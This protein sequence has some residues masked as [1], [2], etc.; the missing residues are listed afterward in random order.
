V[1]ERYLKYRDEG[2][3]ANEVCPGRHTGQFAWHKK[4]LG[5]YA[6][7]SVPDMQSR[8]LESV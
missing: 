2:E 1:E 6:Y 7:G 8:S 3:E 4:T 5:G